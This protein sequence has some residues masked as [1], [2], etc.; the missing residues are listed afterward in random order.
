[1]AQQGQA[2]KAFDDLKTREIWEASR[3]LLVEM[4]EHPDSWEVKKQLMDPVVQKNLAHLRSVGLMG[5]V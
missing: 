5:G 3:T 1:L 2:T 4:Q